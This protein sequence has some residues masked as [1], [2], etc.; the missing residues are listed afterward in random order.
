MDINIYNFTE[1]FE[2]SNERK[3]KKDLVQCILKGAPLVAQM[4]KNLPN[5]AGEA[6]T[7]ILVRDDPLEEGMATAAFLP[8]E[9]RGQRSLAGY[10]S[11]GHKESDTNK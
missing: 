6:G 3:L 11:W 10:S 4:R 5:N 1:L 2:G 8:G 9:S 7:I